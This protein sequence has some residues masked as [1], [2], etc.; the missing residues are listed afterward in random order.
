MARSRC[1][2]ASFCQVLRVDEVRVTLDW[3]R[4]VVDILDDRR[5]PRGHITLYPLRSEASPVLSFLRIPRDLVGRRS[6]TTTRQRQEL[7][8][9]ALASRYR[10][11]TIATSLAVASSQA[12]VVVGSSAGFR[13]FVGHSYRPGDSALPYIMAS[14]AQIRSNQF[15]NPLKF[16]YSLYDMVKS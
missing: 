15:A 12:I 5:H 1:A 6:A 4:R 2:S 8:A 14:C 10:H 13:F 3:D 7:W 11:S 9:N 16:D